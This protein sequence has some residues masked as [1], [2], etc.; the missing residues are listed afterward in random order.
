MTSRNRKRSATNRST[1]LTANRIKR[2]PQFLLSPLSAAVVGAMFSSTTFAQNGVLEEIVVT[3]TKREIN[4]QDVGQSIT[5]FSTADLEKMGIKSMD[6]YVKALPSVSLTETQPGR[7]ALVMRGINNDSFSYRTDSQVALYLDEQPLT[8]N[9][10][11]VSVRTI[12]MERVESLP[13]PQ[14]TLFGSSSQTGTIRLITN[15]PNFDGMSGQLEAGYGSIKDGGDS[16]D[17]SGHLNVPIIDDVLAVR[18]V[19]YNSLDGGYVD[20]VLGKTLKGNFDNANVVE[21]DFNEYEVFGGRISAL[22]NISDNW[23]ALFAVV[24]ETTESEGSWDTDPYLGD[25]K[26]TRFYDEWRDDDWYSAAM[27]LEGDLGFAALTATVTH[28]DRDIAYEWDNMA[29]AHSKDRYFGGGLYYEAYQAGDPYYY[30]YPNYGLYDAG[31]TASSIVNDQHQERDTIE[32]RL[33]SQGESKLQWMVGGFYEEIY[34]EWYYYT[35]QPDLMSTR[36]WATA[37]AYAYYY[38]NYYDVTYPL[39]ATDVGYSNTMERTV[40]QIAVFGELGYD[41]T[42][43]WSVTGGARW[44]EFERDEWDRYQFPEGLAAGGG[45][46][47]NGEYG[48]KGKA[49]DVIYKFATNYAFDDD[50]MA[51][52]LFSQGFRL[53]GVNSQRAAN[54]GLVPRNYDSD[55]LNNYELGIKSL[56]FDG[57]VKLNASL[58]LMTWDDYQVDAGGFDAWWLRGKTNGEGAETKGLEV[59]SSWKATDRLL[60]EASLFLADPEFTDDYTY[61]NGDELK[62]GMTMPGSP[63]TSAWFAVT[64]DLPNVLGGDMWFWYD[65]SYQSESWNDVGNI[66]SNNKNGLA[67]SWTSSNLQVGLDLPSQWSFT[68]K[69]NNLF[70]QDG[71]GWVNTYDNGDAD[72]FDDPRFHNLRAMEQPRTMW[73]TARKRF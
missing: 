55:F 45:H 46:D 34:D 23:S 35:K 50:R 24:G 57:S 40:E 39:E 48:D 30:N 12:D 25:H 14:G 9:S 38:A 27:T 49:D 33:A 58:F 53:G 51:Y 37:Q 42:D 54:T 26:I 66:I 73:L 3:A 22:W 47:V 16:Y 52:F 41:I 7:N 11:Q 21:K 13:G 17:L 18:A 5:A 32:I 68:L 63:D 43:K 15:K 56:W 67:P 69:V 36:A 60:F 20:N 59:T 6:Q 70:D 44:A 28:F 8:T 61:P 29:Y 4:L 1:E 2:A 31:Y 10:Q 71:Y 64:Y 19:A 65:I 62:E 72:T